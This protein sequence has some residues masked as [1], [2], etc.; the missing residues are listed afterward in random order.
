MMLIETIN[1]NMVDRDID[2]SFFGGTIGA[3]WEV[4]GVEVYSLGDEGK[5]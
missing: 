4:G 3:F 1:T 2:F 5:E